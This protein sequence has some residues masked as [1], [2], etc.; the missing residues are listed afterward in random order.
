MP[1]RRGSRRAREGRQWRFGS[2]AP[3]GARARDAP[4][5]RDR[6]T[7]APAPRTRQR[8]PYARGAALVMLPRAVRQGEIMPKGFTRAAQRAGWEARTARQQTC[9]RSSADRHRA[10]GG[11]HHEQE[12]H[13]RGAQRTRHPDYAGS[14]RWDHPQVGGEDAGIERLVPHERRSPMRPPSPHRG[15]VRALASYPSVA[16]VGAVGGVIAGRSELIGQAARS[17]HGPKW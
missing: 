6:G 15:R 4:A 17:H 2:I 13:R 9:G 1:R 3:C 12:R 5:G 16:V 14:G 8:A 11:R 7:T 10:A